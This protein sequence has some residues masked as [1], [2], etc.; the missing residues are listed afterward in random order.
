MQLV[1]NL[2]LPFMAAAPLHAF[3]KFAAYWSETWVLIFVNIAAPV[4]PNL[5]QRGLKL[6]GIV[7]AAISVRRHTALLIIG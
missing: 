7:F 3:I 5:R 4:V 6:K 2:V 1:T